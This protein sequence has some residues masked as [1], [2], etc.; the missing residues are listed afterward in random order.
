MSYTVVSGSRQRVKK[1][2]SDVSLLQ[3]VCRTVAKSGD[4]E[5]YSLS[6]DKPW[7]MKPIEQ[8]E[9]ELRDVISVREAEICVHVGK[10]LK[11]KWETIGEYNYIRYEKSDTQLFF[12]TPRGG[13]LG[14][15]DL[16]ERPGR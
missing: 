15:E 12:F 2:I 8:S 10:S 7:S 13:I 1:Y 9:K 11:V 16:S 14:Y 3:T 4:Y 6:L 5:F